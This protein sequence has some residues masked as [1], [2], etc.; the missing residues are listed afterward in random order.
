MLGWW[1]EAWGRRPD[2]GCGSE[3]CPGVPSC[4]CTSRPTPPLLVLPAG[5]CLPFPLLASAHTLLCQESRFK[6][7]LNNL[8]PKMCCQP[9]VTEF[10][11]VTY[12]HRLDVSVNVC[13]LKQPH[14]SSSQLYRVA[15]W[16]GSAGHSSYLSWAHSCTQ[17][18]LC[19]C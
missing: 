13:C 3:G 1:A 12:G 8:S 14:L 4:M 5:L 9:A 2:P 10:F 17:S 11:L 15:L 18:Q 6:V 19:V 16:A 7:L